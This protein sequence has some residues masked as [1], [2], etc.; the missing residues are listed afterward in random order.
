VTVEAAPLRFADL[1]DLA[2]LRATGADILDLLHRLSTQDLKSLAV[3]EGRPTVLTSPKGRIVERL[4]VHRI[5]ER[6]VLIVGGAGRE[7]AILEHLR[8]Y[9]FREETGLSGVTSE[10]AQI[11]TLGAGLPPPL[12]DPGPW[13]ARA[14]EIDGAAVTVLGH[15]GFTPAGRSL[16]TSAARRDVVVRLLAAAGTEVGASALETWRVLEGLP[17]CGAELTEDANP[18]EAGLRDHVSFTKGCYVGQEVVARLNTYD[19]VSRRLVG[20]EVE[21]DRVPERGAAVLVSGQPV[22]AVT[23]SVALPGQG[24]VVALAYAKLRAL[25]ESR[26]EAEI[27]GPSGPLRARFVDLPLPWSP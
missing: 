24:R 25:E 18:L 15:D 16:V 1:S 2:R 13:G 21:G 14:A 23:S 11:A 5:A 22:G 3:G 4:F 20:L 10:T 12:P 6:E 17:A 27:A 7:Q 26:G 19:K 8:R 9:T